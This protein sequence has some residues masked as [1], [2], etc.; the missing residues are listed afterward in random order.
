MRHDSP[1]QSSSALTV[2]LCAAAIDPAGAAGQPE[3]AADLQ[4][5]S[6]CRFADPAPLLA[7]AAAAGLPG[8]LCRELRLSYW[9]AAHEW[10]EAL[11]G[12]PDT[13]VKV[14]LRRGR[15]PQVPSC[16]LLAEL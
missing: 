12:M 14:R 5:L 3:G 8:A 15:G 11:C 9:L 1:R 6:P 13:P 10:W 4:P 7:A 16:G 2:S